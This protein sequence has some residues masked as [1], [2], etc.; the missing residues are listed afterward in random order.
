MGFFYARHMR[1]R[2]LREE[3]VRHTTN[4]G[5]APAFETPCGALPAGAAPFSLRPFARYNGPGKQ[6]W[7]M[8]IL[9]MTWALAL[10]P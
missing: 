6:H 4:F 7:F 5:A 2:L 9:V 1:F 8:G 10:R 3:L